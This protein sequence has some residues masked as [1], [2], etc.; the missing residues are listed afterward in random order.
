M[1]NSV[2][3]DETAHE[4]SHLDLHCL[5]KRLSRSTRSKV[6]KQSN[7]RIFHIVVTHVREMLRL[8]F[9]IRNRTDHY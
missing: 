5:Q 2:D 6:F 8:L 7:V 4:P 9:L 1:A 3:P